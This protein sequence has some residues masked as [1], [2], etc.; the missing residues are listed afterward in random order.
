MGFGVGESWCNPREA[1]LWSQIKEIAREVPADVRDQ[2]VEFGARWR[3]NQFAYPRFTAS[4]A[5]VG[6][7]P[8]SPA[9]RLRRARR[10]MCEQEEFE[11]SGVLPA[12]EQQ[13]TAL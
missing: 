3:A 10:R 5:A 7:G 6:C 2:L 11:T 1:T 13:K 12:R 9:S 8:I 4:A